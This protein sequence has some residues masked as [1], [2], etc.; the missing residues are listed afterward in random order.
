MFLFCFV[1]FVVLE[2]VWETEGVAHFL[3]FLDRFGNTGAVKLRF[4]TVTFEF[5]WPR[6]QIQ[7]SK[8]LESFS[9]DLTSVISGMI[10]YAELHLFLPL[11]Y[12]NLAVTFPNNLVLSSISTFMKASSE[13]G[14]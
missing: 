7:E 14:L 9:R 13:F 12:V 11:N 10:W 6:E 4:F 5:G 1:C 8:D 3:L 2:S